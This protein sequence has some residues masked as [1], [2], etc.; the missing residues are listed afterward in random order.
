[1]TGQ[2][3]FRLLTA[4]EVAQILRLKPAT[5]YEAASVGRIPCVRLWKG[6][7]KTLVRFRAED[8]DRII[9]E[10]AVPTIHSKE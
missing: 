2:I 7:R 3:A 4:E 10:R 9:R 8:I 1:M 6:R 5:V